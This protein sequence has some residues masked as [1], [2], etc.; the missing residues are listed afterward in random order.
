[1]NHESPRQA[2]LRGFAWGALGGVS[3]VALMYL[4]NLLFALRPLPQLLGGPVLSIMPGPVFGFLID[5]LQHA[6]KVVE[7]IGLIVAMVISLG[8]LGAAWALTARRWAWPHTAMLF[9][10]VGWLVLSVIV[11][12]ITGTGVLGLN[13]GLTTPIVWAVL[14]AVYGVILQMGAPT[15]TAGTTDLDRRRLLST[16]PV[17]IGVVSFGAL[18]VQL[19]PNWFRA[20]FNP[21]ESGLKGPPL[22]VTPTRYFYVVSK[23]IGGDPTVDAQSWVLNVNGL[24]DNPMRLT[25]VDL[26]GLPSVTQYATLECISNNVGGDL[27]STGSFTGV[28]LRDL[29]ATAKPQ[30]GGTWAAFKAR[31]GYTESLP[32]TL[33]DGAPEIL[34]AYSLGGEALPMAHGYPARILIPG[35]YGMKGPKW[36][37]SIQLVDHESGG[38]WEQQGWDHNA[39]VKTMARI[40][41]PLDGDIVKLGAVSLSGVA[42]AGTRG[43]GKVEYSADGGRS[44]TEAQ[45]RP[46]LSNLTWVLWSAEWSPGAEGS[47]QLA[48]RTT[49]GAGQAQDPKS[50]PSYPSGATGYHSIRVNV[51][52]A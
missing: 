4:S 5:N 27:I 3:L 11:L 40:D 10:G 7:E 47:Y 18:A 32:M 36:L 23:N 41:V 33:I 34:V 48:V 28:R 8:L 52:G 45:M 21:P 24:V 37:E 38:Y 13:D 26:L 42:F 19:V 30:S 1:M 35:H 44:W 20:V 51:G 49:D 39:V 2:A 12:P 43:I 17:T 25:L 14:F 6:G 15:Q 46:P 31:D 22:E 9:A 50:A 16:L 29:I